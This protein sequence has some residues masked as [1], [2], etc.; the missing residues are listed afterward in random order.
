MGAFL[1]KKR[2]FAWAHKET[3]VPRVNANLVVVLLR[4][5]HG[6]MDVFL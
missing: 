6:Y 3:N 4:A 5:I 2:A 1:S